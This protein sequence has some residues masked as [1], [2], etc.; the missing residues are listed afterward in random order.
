MLIPSFIT[1]SP[2]S[3]QSLESKK[4]LKQ[5][6]T[7]DLHTK[8]SSPSTFLLTLAI[9]CFTANAFFYAHTLYDTF[10]L[11]TTQSHYCA[12][13]E[14]KAAQWSSEQ[15]RNISLASDDGCSVYAF[16]YKK[17]AKMSFSDALD[18]VV[19]GDDE[20]EV[21]T[22]SELGG[23]IV[24]EGDRD[25]NFAT[26]WSLVCEKEEVASRLSLALYVGCIFGGFV[27]G[28]FGDL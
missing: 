25:E 8:G 5:T 27:L 19:E 2:P 22:C 16:N 6:V 11:T 15:I 28:I 10:A 21:K 4:T 9:T 7:D 13:P 17:I 12:V 23:V 24:F 18:F 26:E 3:S 1:T 20:P 14:L